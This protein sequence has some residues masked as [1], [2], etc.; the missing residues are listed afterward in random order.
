MGTTVSVMPEGFTVEECLRG[1][2]AGSD[3]V[4]QVVTARAGYFAVRV[5]PGQFGWSDLRA[6]FDPLADGSIVSAVIVLYG[7]NGRT[8]STKMMDEISG[9]YV[10]GCGAAFLDHLS[11]LKANVPGHATEWR[12]RVLF[13]ARQLGELEA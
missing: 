4:A 3:I 12:A 13:H 5:R 10:A 8:L 11:P 9:P 7:R 6:Y 2:L 1:C